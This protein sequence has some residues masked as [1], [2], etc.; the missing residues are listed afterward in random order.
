MILAPLAPATALLASQS[1]G[2]TGGMP[3]TLKVVMCGEEDVLL[4]EGRSQI[5][6]VGNRPHS[7]FPLGMWGIE[8]SY[9]FF[10]VSVGVAH[11]HS[12]RASRFLG[13]SPILFH[14][15]K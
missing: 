14:S 13:S 6:P 12:L 15:S 9:L 7:S 11:S 5:R 8:H 1:A 2:Q 4:P 3:R 10:K